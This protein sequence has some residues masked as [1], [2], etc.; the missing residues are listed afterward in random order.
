MEWGNN[1]AEEYIED[2]LMKVRQLQAVLERDNP[3][4][5]ALQGIIPSIRFT[6]VKEMDIRVVKTDDVPV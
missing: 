3:R 4:S 5:P 1:E 6:E 2:A